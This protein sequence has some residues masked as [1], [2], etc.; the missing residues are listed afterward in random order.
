MFFLKYFALS[1]VYVK[2]IIVILCLIM[3]LSL[4]MALSKFKRLNYINSYIKSF[5]E[6]FWSGTAL[7]EFYKTNKDDLKHPL[8]MIF[9]AVYEEWENSANI[10]TKFNSKSDLKERMLN[11]AHIQKM[12]TLKVC[13]RYLDILALFVY[14]S[15]FLG[16]LGTIIGLIDVFY[17]LDIENGLTILSSATGIGGSLISIVIAMISAIIAMFFHWWF[18]LKLRDVSDKIDVFIVDLL[19]LLGRELDVI[20]VADKSST[21]N[22]NITSSDDISKNVNIP[23]GKIDNNV[24][25][26]AEKT[27]TRPPKQAQF[28]EDDDV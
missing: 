4:T 25:E 5:E 11:V 8:G 10:R 1:S 26:S 14:L 19:N 22:D 27:T 28:N 15:P 7:D 13:E 3:I 6:T 23:S 2:L 20:A 17:N 16:L 24:K 9:K 21:G 18:N 12:N